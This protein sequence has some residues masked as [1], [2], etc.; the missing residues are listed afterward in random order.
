MTT[1]AMARVA[2]YR[3]RQRERGLCEERIWLPDTKTANLAELARA[4]CARMN[5]ADA[6]DEIADALQ[7][8]AL[9]D[10]GLDN[11]LSA[12]HHG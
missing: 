8:I 5:E 4:A 7:A 2:A 3:S 10:D 1:T 6:N 9:Q 11:R 12:Q